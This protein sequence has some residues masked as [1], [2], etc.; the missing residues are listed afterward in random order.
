[1]NEWKKQSF[2]TDDVIYMAKELTGSGYSLIIWSCTEGWAM[3]AM[4]HH[5]ASPV[6]DLEEAKRLCEQKAV[7]FLAGWIEDITGKDVRKEAI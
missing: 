5:V 3:L 1:M 6:A 4:G 2:S 7:D